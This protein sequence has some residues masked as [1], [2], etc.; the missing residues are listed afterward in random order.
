MYSLTYRHVHAKL[1]DSNNGWAIPSVLV[2]LLFEKLATWRYGN[3][4]NYKHVLLSMY[5]LS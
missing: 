1:R 3:C 2:S 5:M 4:V